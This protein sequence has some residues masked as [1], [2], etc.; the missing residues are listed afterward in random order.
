M[1]SCVRLNRLYREDFHA[2]LYGPSPASRARWYRLY[3]AVLPKRNSDRGCFTALLPDD[4]AK[5]EWPT[6]LAVPLTAG[7][8]RRHSATAGICPFACGFFSPILCIFIHGFE[9]RH[10]AVADL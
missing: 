6:V 1:L 7:R 4:R 5:R 9:W 8:T 10:P 2:V 3:F